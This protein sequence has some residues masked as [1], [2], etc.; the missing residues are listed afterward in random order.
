MA[1]QTYTLNIDV[2]AKSVADLETQLEQV[3]TELKDLDRNSDAFKQATKDAQLLTKELKKVENEIEGLT[4]EKKIQAA[5]GAIKTMGGSIASVVGTLGVLG[6]ESEAF[7]EIEKRAASA[8]AVA[9]GFKDVSEGLSQMASALKGVTAAQIK[10]NYAALANPYVAL[11]GAV[12]AL[13]GAFAKYASKLTNDVVPVTTTLKNMFLSMGNWA[14]FAARQGKSFTDEMSRIKDENVIKD[15][16][17]AI[18]VYRGFGKD[19]LDLELQLAEKKLDA[20]K[21]GEEGY[22]EAQREAM[23]LRAQ[24]Y[25][26]GGE[27]Q[28]EAERKAYEEKL[29]VL[30]LK[31]QLEEEAAGFNKEYYEMFGHESAMTFIEAF[32]KTVQEEEFDPNSVLVLDEI[33]EEDEAN[34]KFLENLKKRVEA[35]KVADE[36]ISQSR[37]MLLDVIQNVA[38]QESAIG[39]AAFIARQA[40]LIKELAVEAKASLTR[41]AQKGAEATVD[42]SAG[43]IKT[44]A[45]GF[46]Q[47]IPLLLAYG[48][49]VGALVASMIKAVKKAKAPMESISTTV[50]SVAAAAPQRAVP[51][52]N[53]TIQQLSAG[54]AIKTYVLAGE[55]TSAQEANAKLKNRRSLD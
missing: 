7:G 36:Q 51:L 16:E 29:K 37:L 5:D 24:I 15:L 38:D 54:T 30:Q 53:D 26:Q 21:E 18:A 33:T 55:T 17:D 11:A 47:N 50:P 27:K 45:A 52:T 49:Q 44:A 34:E 40:L 10:A 9:V 19:T 13:T 8:I 4:F 48:V 32:K 12:V 25:T 20:L 28:A 2:N 14:D 41:I 23:V 35:N 6:V 39:K 3:N 1:T 46:P 31:W 42:A 43:F 22:R